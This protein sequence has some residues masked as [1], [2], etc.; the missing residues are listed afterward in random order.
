MI[1]LKFKIESYYSNNR[2]FKIIYISNNYNDTLKLSDILKSLYKKYGIDNKEEYNIDIFNI[3]KLFWKKHFSDN[4]I[5]NLEYNLS[6]Y[7]N[8]TLK[9]LEKQFS[10][11]NLEIPL[12][13]N[14]NDAGRSVGN[15]NG[16]SF[17]FHSNEKD[18]HHIPH[19]HCKY[20]GIETRINI[21][22]L[23]IID[24]PFKKNKMDYALNIVK[25]NQKDLLLYWQKVVING[26]SLKFNL[27][28]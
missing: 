15:N 21:A 13:L 20:S 5:A 6:D 14:Y 3:N 8:L 26:E 18:L 4:I 22:N 27:K 25:E 2:K 10:I 7:E 28:L 24:K 19:I 23:T 12:C 9:Q 17:Y 1:K 11:S 16:I